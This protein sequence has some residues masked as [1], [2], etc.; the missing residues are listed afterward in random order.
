MPWTR[1]DRAARPFL[2]AAGWMSVAASLLHIACIIGGPDWYRFFGAGEPM[3]LAAERGSLVPA[4]LTFVI[5]AILAVWALFAFGAAGISWRPPLARTALIAIATVLLLR[6]AMAFVPAFWPPE[7]QT[8][9]FIITTS[10]ICFV[11]G[12]SFAIGTWLSWPQLS[13]RT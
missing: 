9:A 5:A 1:D 12:A 7:N 10:A 2:L 4:M 11:M 13:Q 3:A 8:S 6:A